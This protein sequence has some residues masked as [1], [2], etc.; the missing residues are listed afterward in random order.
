MKINGFG[1]S[2]A[3]IILIGEHAVVYGHPGI[4]I[5][6][7]PL[8]TKVKVSVNDEDFLSSSLFKGS[9]SNIPQELLFIKFMVDELRTSLHYG[10]VMVE[11]D[12]RIPNSAGMGGSA[13]IS[14]ALVQA[15]YDLSGSPLTPKLRF[16]KT[17][18][19]E[20]L[21]HGSASGIDALTTTSDHAWYFIKGKD[22]EKLNIKLPGYL[23][24]ANTG[25]KGSTK[26]AVGKVAKLFTQNLAQGHLESLGLMAILVKEAIEKSS[27]EEI[28]K[29]LNQAHFH[30]QELGVSHPKLD[31]MVEEAL[32]LGALG[33]KLTG[34]GLG[35]SMIALVESKSI[36]QKIIQHFKKKHTQEVWM[37]DLQA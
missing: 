33:A 31:S 30:L 3:K 20:K 23:V 17:Q 22:P 6:F 36:A 37:M 13:A 9:M 15:L 5:P 28:A 16:E 12:N 32:Q 7:L 1:V 35:G 8:E 34:G 27:V 2:H 19:A 14:G 4:A 25:V 18:L 10:P 26:E 24:V 21:V 29:Y 11:I